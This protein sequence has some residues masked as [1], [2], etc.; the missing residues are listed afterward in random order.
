MASKV[1]TVQVESA[2][3]PRMD[4]RR[5]SFEI[6]KQGLRARV[7]DL[8]RQYPEQ[9]AKALITACSKAIENFCNSQVTDVSQLSQAQTLALSAISTTANSLHRMRRNAARR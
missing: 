3:W 8:E 7:T 4:L 1:Q 6:Q 9:E 5:Q 2:R